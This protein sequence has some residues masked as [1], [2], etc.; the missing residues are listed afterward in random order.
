MSKMLD[1]LFISVT[2]SALNSLV[3]YRLLD[4]ADLLAWIYYGHSFPIHPGNS[5]SSQNPK[6]SWRKQG[7]V[8]RIAT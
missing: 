8:G 1:P 3:Y 5:I 6:C 2:D 7:F 4:H